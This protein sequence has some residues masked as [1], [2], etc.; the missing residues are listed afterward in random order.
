M[1]AQVPLWALLLLA[2]TIAALCFGV[3]IQKGLNSLKVEL[4]QTRQMCRDLGDEV[5]RKDQVRGD[6]IASVTT[7]LQQ[8]D[9]QVVHYGD[10]IEA[11]Q[12][13]D[14]QVITRAKAPA[15]K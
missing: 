5:D 11:V 12:M 10:P 9:R 3:Q 1:K 8:K 2:L 7:E 4:A 15:T 14:V 13:G 6:Q